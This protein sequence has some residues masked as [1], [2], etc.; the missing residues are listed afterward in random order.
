MVKKKAAAPPKADSKKPTRERGRPPVDD[1]K[2]LTEKFLA[3]FTKT[4]FSEIT[5]FE[6]EE[7]VNEHSEATRRLVRLGLRLRRMLKEGKISFSDL[8]D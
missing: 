4:D 6:Q 8:Q 7:N 2:K 3:S 5:R 1:S